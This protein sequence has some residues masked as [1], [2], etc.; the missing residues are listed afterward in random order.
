MLCPS[1]EAEYLKGYC[2]YFTYEE[3]RGQRHNVGL[4]GSVPYV[5]SLHLPSLA[6]YFTNR[7]RLELK[8]TK[9]VP[10]RNVYMVDNR[11]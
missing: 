8:A 11:G 9:M 4:D 2:H 10:S 5:P 1:H 7:I 3:T 6:E